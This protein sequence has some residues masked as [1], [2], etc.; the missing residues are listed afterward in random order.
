[1]CDFPVVDSKGSAGAPAEFDVTPEMIEEG[2]RTLCLIVDSPD[3]HPV[4]ITGDELK[5]VYIAMRRLE[6]EMTPRDHRALR[7]RAR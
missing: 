2:E 5:A 7:E 6:P 3:V 4:L 1:M